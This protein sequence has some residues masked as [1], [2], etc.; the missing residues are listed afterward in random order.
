MRN[1]C[2]VKFGKLVMTWV[3]MRLES[4]KIMGC[5]DHFFL[6]PSL[7]NPLPSRILAVLREVES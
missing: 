6:G 1:N 3:D 7:S 5:P 2:A 4:F